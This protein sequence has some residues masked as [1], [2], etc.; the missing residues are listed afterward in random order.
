MPYSTYEQSEDN[1]IARFE[2]ELQEYVSTPVQD[3]DDREKNE[4]E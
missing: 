4:D 3:D 2:R 1:S